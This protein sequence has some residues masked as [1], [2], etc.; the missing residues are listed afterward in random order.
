METESGSTPAS[1]SATGADAS[2]SSTT[3]ATT[4]ELVL[5]AGKKTKKLFG[6]GIFSNPTRLDVNEA[7]DPDVVW[8]LNEH[9]LPFGDGSFDEIH[10]YEV[11]EHLGAQGDYEFFFS[12]WNE[13][14]RILKTGGHFYATVPA[15]HSPWLWGD[16]SHRRVICKETLVFLDQREYASQVGRTPMSDFRHI[17]RGDF[18]VRHLQTHGDLFAFVLR[19]RDGID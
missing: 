4:C 5:G 18:E 9:P 14:H 8:D 19:K 10:A 17:Y 16:P 7:H 11:L 2:A 3:S 13:Y 15:L 6:N 12:E 1:S